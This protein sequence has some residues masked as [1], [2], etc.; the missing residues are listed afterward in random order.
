MLNLINTVPV[1]HNFTKSSDPHQHSISTVPVRP[2]YKSTSANTATSTTYQCLLAPSTLY[3]H[4]HI[5]LKPYRWYHNATNI[6]PVWSQIHQHPP[7]FQRHCISNIQ[8]TSYN[9]SLPLHVD[10]I[11]IA[12]IIHKDSKS[13]AIYHPLYQLSTVHESDHL[14]ALDIINT[15]SLPSRVPVLDH[16]NTMSFHHTFINVRSYQHECQC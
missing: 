4:Y 9:I 12:H 2:F 14:P 11:S 1:Q 8:A 7:N 5:S 10:F 6:D 15:I 16:V 3:S 13:I